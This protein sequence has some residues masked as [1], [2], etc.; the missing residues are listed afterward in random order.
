[1]DEADRQA[2]AEARRQRATIVKGTLGAPEHDFDPLSGHAAISLVTR[3]SAESWSLSGRPQPS[4]SRREIPCR[5]VPGRL[6]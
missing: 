5:F 3:L 2:R 1:M 6:P 4:Y